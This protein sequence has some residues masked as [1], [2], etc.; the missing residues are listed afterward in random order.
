MG[1]EK[2]RMR[3]V[4]FVPCEY[5]ASTR[6]VRISCTTSTERNLQPPNELLQS[7]KTTLV[8]S[9]TTVRYVFVKCAVRLTSNIQCPL[10][11]VACETSLTFTVARWAG[12][13]P[14]LSMNFSAREERG[15]YSLL[16][17][18][19][20]CIHFK[21]RFVR[22]SEVKELNSHKEGRR[23]LREF[24]CTD[25]R[26]GLFHQQE[27]CQRGFTHCKIYNVDWSARQFL[28]LRGLLTWDMREP[29][30]LAHP[31]VFDLK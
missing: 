29:L 23:R 10:C 26:Q 6:I 20:E 22:F 31:K 27:I 1:D 24:R 12:L 11:E 15:E 19:A 17:I 13:A 4:R 5:N 28:Q 3:P 9:W 2:A 25:S 16:E 8:Q 7:I 21:M 30:W 18:N 14:T